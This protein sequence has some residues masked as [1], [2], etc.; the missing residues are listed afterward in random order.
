MNA[1][2]I[3]KIL[4]I[5]LGPHIWLPAL[6][7]AS[8]L[9]SG[10]SNSR[11]YILL[12]SL[13]LFQILIPIA[14]I[15]IVV[16]LGKVTAWDLPKREERHLFLGVSLISYVISIIIIKIFGNQLLFNLSLII[17]FLL[18]VLIITTYFWKISL[19]ASMNTAGS[20][21]VNFLFDWSLHW[22]YLA[23]PIIFWARYKLKR[24]NILQLIAG[25]VTSGAVV[26]GAFYYLKYI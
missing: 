7:I 3:A 20:I 2:K 22:L 8:I 13:F 18:I 17:L 1:E 14:Y 5:A 10:L 6:L 4:S 26:L 21:I 11:I 25:T 16:K 9:R 23:V 24:H 12:P 19:H 15:H